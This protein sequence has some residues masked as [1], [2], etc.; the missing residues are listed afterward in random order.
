VANIGFLPHAFKYL[1][2]PDV[3][4]NMLQPTLIGP[5]GKL[6]MHKARKLKR[7]LYVW[8]VNEEHWM[9]WSIRKKVDG[10]ITDDP[11]LFLEVCDRYVLGG[12]GAERLSTG[13]PST[14]RR[15]RLYTT[16]LMF[17]YFVFFMNIVFWARVG[18]LGRRKP[19]VVPTQAR[20]PTAA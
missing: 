1:K 4:F 7:K 3:D 18:K 15:M 5:C 16:G 17:Q 2:L 13:G 11:K 8:T 14:V 12:G 20:V 19:R 6:F 9:E 10:V